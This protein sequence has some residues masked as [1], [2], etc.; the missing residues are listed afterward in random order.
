M[1]ESE[2]IYHTIKIHRDHIVM[3]LPIIENLVREDG[4]GDAYRHAVRFANWG[5]RPTLEN[6]RGND[7]S[8]RIEGPRYTVG[9]LLYPLGGQILGP[10]GVSQTNPVETNA[11]TS[12]VR[13]VI[14]TALGGWVQT[15]RQPHQITSCRQEIDRAVADPIALQCMMDAAAGLTGKQEA[16]DGK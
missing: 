14:D 15:N 11:V 12:L 13:Q 10:F 7:V 16:S 4:D 8:F 3:I 6:F 2:F 9:G 1:S 5:E